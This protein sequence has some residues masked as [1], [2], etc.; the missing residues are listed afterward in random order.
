M[1]GAFVGNGG[2][3]RMSVDATALDTYA[4]YISPQQRLL[5]D[6]NV[7]FEEYR[8]YAEK[9]RAEEVALKASEVGRTGFMQIL[10][11][12]KSSP[13]PV[14]NSQGAVGE[15]DEKGNTRRA[16]S[17]NANLADRSTREVVTME[18][19]TN[20]SRAFRTATWAACFYLITTDILGPFG[21]GYVSRVHVRARSILI[22]V[23]FPSG[24]SDGGR[25]SVCSP[26]LV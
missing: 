26:S 15:Y 12:P 13:K 1:A 19:W 4:G 17:V 9:T 20:A 16:S 21:V 8:Y 3:P 7:T 25:A 11:P 10:F 23:D 5:H 14:F 22:A 24:R 6:P 18:E 2:D